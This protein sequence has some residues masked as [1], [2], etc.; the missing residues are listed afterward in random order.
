MPAVFSRRAQFDSSSMAIYLIVL[1]CL[2]NHVCFSG[3]RVL[4]SLYALNLGANQ[5]TIGILM[6]LY[7][8]LP[9][10]LA[11]YAGRLADRLGPRRPM[12]LGTT[13]VMIAMLLPPLFPGIVALHVSALMIG[14]SFHFF[15][16]SVHG[17]AGGV[18]GDG[19]RA[20]N[21]A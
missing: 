12:L 21:Y 10:L 11:I 13:G 2:M 18:G 14:S 4:V 20:R 19:N 16:V 8:I 7:A 15:F 3:S 17:T 5:F 1:L 6:A 9:M